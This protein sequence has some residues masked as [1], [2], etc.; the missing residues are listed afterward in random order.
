MI[1]FLVEYVLNNTNNV[2]NQ[3]YVEKTAETFVR[4]QV[5]DI[6][7]AKE[8]IK[9]VSKVS[10]EKAMRANKPSESKVNTTNQHNGSKEE[11]ENLKRQILEKVE[12]Q[13]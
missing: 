13:K 3:K 7:S 2:L 8:L 11:L 9:K 10:K 5:N 6:T 4:N 12:R 1:N